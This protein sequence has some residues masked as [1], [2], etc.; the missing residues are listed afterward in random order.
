[1]ELDEPQAGMLAPTIIGTFPLSGFTKKHCQ[2][3]P[4][5]SL[6]HNAKEVRNIA[7]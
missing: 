3:A 6:C 1:M 4:R 7:S 5:E 2:L